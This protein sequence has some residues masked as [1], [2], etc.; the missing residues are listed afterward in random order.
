[1]SDLRAIFKRRK[2]W[3]CR[4]PRSRV[5]TQLE[6]SS[7]QLEHELVALTAPLLAEYEH[8][9]AM[10]K[11]LAESELRAGRALPDHL[12]GCRYTEL[13][14]ATLC[15]LQQADM[16]AAAQHRA[17]WEDVARQRLDVQL[18]DAS[19]PAAVALKGSASRVCEGTDGVTKTLADV[20]MH[21]CV[22][23]DELESPCSALALVHELLAQPSA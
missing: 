7:A 13:L 14:L 23:L 6:Q 9:H 10:F 15:V 8:L 4:R 19:C 12:L 18:F 1:M 21:D 22:L 3:A 11:A 5:A 2:D 17:H 20:V 16:P